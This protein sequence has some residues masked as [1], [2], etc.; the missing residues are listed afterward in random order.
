MS[1]AQVVIKEIDISTRVPGFPGVYGAICIP[2]PKGPIDKP[3]LVTSDS[4]LLKIFT[5]YETVKVGYYDSFFSAL[6]FLQS[7]TTLWVRRVV[8]KGACIAGCDSTAASITAW[9]SK[10]INTVDDVTP[11]V[12][13]I[14]I[15]SKDPG[16]W[17]NSV[18]VEIAPYCKQQEVTIATENEIPLESHPYSDNWV[19]VY[20]T[21][22]DGN[23]IKSEITGGDT[24]FETVVSTAYLAKV[25]NSH[26]LYLDSE[27][28]QLVNLPQSSKVYIS[29]ISTYNIKTENT[30]RVLEY[31]D[32][33]LK[34][35]Y[36]VSTYSGSKD[37]NN[38]SNFIETV[39]EGS[40]Y[41]R[42]VVDS[43]IIDN[44][45]SFQP[46]SFQ[47]VTLASGK[48]DLVT[49]GDIVS[50]LGIFEDTETYNVTAFMDGG[51]PSVAFQKE[52][53]SI[54]E[55]RMDCVGVLS[56]P[57]DSEIALDYKGSIVNFRNNTL[58][59]NS[60]FGALYTP[61]LQ[62]LDKYNNRNIWVA[63][64]G[65]V[66]GAISSTALNY[67][68]W[69]PVGGFKR[70]V[71]DVL[72]TKIH[73]TKGDLD[74]LYDNGVNPIRFYS[75][76]GI[77]IWGQKTLQSTPSMLD[78]LNVRML[79][80]V[81]NP[82]IKEAMEDFLFELNDEETRDRAATIVDNYM[83]DIK[84]RRGVSDYRVVCDDSNNSATDVD[85][86]RMNL[87]IYIIPTTSIEEIPVRM[88][89]T[90]NSISL[91]AAEDLV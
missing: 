25:S 38:K 75:G 19:S 65:F 31:W 51:Y 66:A 56:T 36:D 64:D 67:E 17:G 21:D 24:D 23:S 73:F 4:E 33:A 91:T 50:A 48:D 43:S 59:V 80:V 90:S 49:D 78:R 6:A 82:A 55:S 20:I 71:L 1:S 7:S 84:A 26:K 41:I 44:T 61:H 9:S 63:P 81:I 27:K 58:N 85:N 74:Y 52:I 46:S 28:T 5:P 62:I 60:S 8:G 13:G 47:S 12:G 42:A 40:N 72:D 35:S 57:Y 69:Y 10:Q 16:E 37:G 87:D 53:I 3:Y 54:A 11:P 70:G 83:S 29:P 86:Y 77:V 14:S 68:A 15:V 22:G 45:T 79:L 39:L 89:I 2:A 18:K 30:F 76:K 88:V 34:N 32:G